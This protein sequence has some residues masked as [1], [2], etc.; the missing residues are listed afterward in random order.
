M[1]EAQPP[2][3]PNQELDAKIVATYGGRNQVRSDH[4]A[5]LTSTVR[6]ALWR[7]GMP[8]GGSVA[9]A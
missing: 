3:S 4:L 9:A 7:L 1:P 6:E 5:S 2:A 8:R